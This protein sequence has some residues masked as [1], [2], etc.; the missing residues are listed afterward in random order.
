[1]FFLWLPSRFCLWY[2]L[3]FLFGYFI[4]FVFVF[5]FLLYASGI[6]GL[7]FATN[8]EN[9]QSLFLEYFFCPFSLFPPSE[10]LNYVY[11]GLSDI[12]PQLFGIVFCFFPIFFSF[13]FSSGKFYWCIFNFIDSF[14]DYVKFTDEPAKICFIYVV[15]FFISNISFDFLTISLSLLKFSIC[16]FCFFSR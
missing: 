10:I 15:E 14:L 9:S 3:V 4:W 8:L 1:M 7:V 5:K 13:C 2:V 6:W 11:V 12:V 16:A